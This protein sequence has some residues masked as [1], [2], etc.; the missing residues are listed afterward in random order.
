MNKDVVY[1][2]EEEDTVCGPR[3][4]DGKKVEYGT[5]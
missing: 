2:P 3:G 4:L 1:D 5:D